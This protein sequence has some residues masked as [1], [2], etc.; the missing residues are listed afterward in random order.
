MCLLSCKKESPAIKIPAND[1]LSTRSNLPG[2]ANT[3]VTVTINQNETG[4]YK[5]PATFEGLSYETGILA[6]SPDFLN[7]NNKVLIQLIKNLGGGILRIGGNTSDL[8]GWTGNARTINTPIDSLTTTDIDRLSAFSKAIGWQ[9]LFGLN[10]GQYNV[11]V[12]ANEAQYVHNS[13]QNNLYALQLGNEPDVFYQRRGSQAYNYSNYQQQWSDYFTAVKA[14]VPAARFAGPDV[15]PFN[16]KWVNSF[17]DAEHNNVRL[18]DGHY[19]NNGPASNPTINYKNILTLNPR[20]AGYLIDLNRISAKY[21]LPY[22]ISEC[23]SVYGGGKP[24]TSDVFAS[25]LWA[26]DFMWAVA[27]NKGQ[28]VNFHGG[29]PRF[30]YTPITIANGVVAAR[31]E[32]YAM[33]AFKHGSNGGTIIPAIIV[34][35]RE[36]DNCSVYAC[37]GDSA[38]TITLINKEVSKNFAFTVQLSKTASTIQIARLTA[39][40]VTATSGISFAGTAVNADGSFNPATAKKYTVNQKSFVIN[41][42]AGSAAIVTVR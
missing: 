14:V 21:R 36:N 13:L 18:I 41:V 27:E 26:L 16:D 10:L 2:V 9:V 32:Y 1:T 6:E 20:L 31:P 40:A 17:A 4:G 35:A 15:I 12:A 7:E 30:A 19:Y 34:N 29:Q 33:L 5:I 24:G 39:P 23:N 38:T 8:T 3:P 28:G 25:A 22:R 37:E 42:P 11:A